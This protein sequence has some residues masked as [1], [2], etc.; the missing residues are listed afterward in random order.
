MH[1]KKKKMYLLCNVITEKDYRAKNKC[2]TFCRILLPT[3]TPAKCK[4]GNSIFRSF[5]NKLK[6]AKLSA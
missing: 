3:I 1:Q 4:H 6:S 2:V 5:M